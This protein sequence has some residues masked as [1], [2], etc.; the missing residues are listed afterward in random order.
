M[1]KVALT[2]RQSSILSRLKDGAAIIGDDR[3]GNPL[4]MFSNPSE[5]TVQFR[6]VATFL[7]SGWIAWDGGYRIMPAGEAAYANC[8]IKQ[9][10]L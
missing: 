9:R 3:G 10:G 1:T 6:T 4:G 2:V 8:Q 5:Q 7:G